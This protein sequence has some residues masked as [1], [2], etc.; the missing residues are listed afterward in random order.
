MREHH[1][2]VLEI[3]SLFLVY[4]KQKILFFKCH[5]DVLEMKTV[6]KITVMFSS[7][8]ALPFLLLS[9]IAA[10]LLLSLECNPMLQLVHTAKKEPNPVTFDHSHSGQMLLGLTMTTYW[11]PYVIVKHRVTLVRDVTLCFRINIV[12]LD[13]IVPPFLS[14]PFLNTLH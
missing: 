14:K 4:N 8:S 2:D 1:C 13:N 11:W 5:N 6:K 10:F 7:C 3:C 12:F 9:D